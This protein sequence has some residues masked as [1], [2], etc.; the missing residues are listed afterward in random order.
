MKT[1]ITS[2]G[3]SADYMLDNHFARCAYFIIYDDE[4]GGL[5]IIPN[6]NLKKLENAGPASVDLLL[7]KGVKKVV[8][9]EFGSKIKDLFDRYKIQLVMMR[10]PSRI[11]EIISLLEG[12]RH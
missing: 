6:P 5:E 1:A 9:G 3:Q 2:T 10:K 11:A 7:S 4:N 12:N 8:S